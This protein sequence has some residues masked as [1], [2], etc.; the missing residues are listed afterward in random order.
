MIET[1]SHLANAKQRN[2]INIDTDILLNA[3]DLN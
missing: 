1:S 3:L 2:D